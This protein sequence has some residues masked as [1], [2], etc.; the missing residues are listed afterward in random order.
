MQSHDITKSP[1][2][3][4]F[5]SHLQPMSTRSIQ[6][7]KLSC[8]EIINEMEKEQDALVMRLLR[9]V[10]R[11]KDDNMQLR[12]QLYQSRPP[13]SPRP[14]SQLPVDKDLIFAVHDDYD[15]NY[16]YGMS[17]SVSSNTSARSSLSQSHPHFNRRAS[18]VGFQAGNPSTALPID[19]TNATHSLNIKRGS[20]SVTPNG[21][22]TSSSVNESDTGHHFLR[23]APSELDPRQKV[24]RRWSSI[25]D[26]NSDTHTDTARRLREYELR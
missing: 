10:E 19:T 14:S 8:E 15:M 20:M 2:S 21:S 9:E 4:Q 22:S 5:G 17:D 25:S 13:L 1:R 16:H 24:P 18:P 6:K 3:R 26:S 23:G 11:L 7:R 12:K